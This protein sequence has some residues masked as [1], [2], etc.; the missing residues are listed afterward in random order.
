MTGLPLAQIDAILSVGGVPSKR[1]DGL[2]MLT[3][4]GEAAHPTFEERPST[5]CHRNLTGNCPKGHHNHPTSV[6]RSYL[7]FAL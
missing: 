3:G 1:P 4:K 6:E 7:R 2:A 5:R